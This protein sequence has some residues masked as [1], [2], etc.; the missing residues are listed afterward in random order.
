[1]AAMAPSHTSLYKQEK[2]AW[3]TYSC[4]MSFLPEEK[5][6]KA[7]C[8]YFLTPASLELGHM[9]VPDLYLAKGNR[10]ARVLL[11]QA[12]ATVGARLSRTNS[13]SEL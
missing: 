2:Q 3:E 1:M 12:R 7:S 11:G 9:A 5:N 6:S 10:F 8:S 4:K 13:G